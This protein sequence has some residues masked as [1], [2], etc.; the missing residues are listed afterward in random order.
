MT[1]RLAVFASGTG[2]NFASIAQAVRDRA[3]DVE[4][5]L[6][7]CDNPGAPVL[8]RAREF[9][10]PTLTFTPADCGTRLGYEQRILDSLLAESIDL[11]A[12]AG[13]MRIVRSPLLEAYA[14][15]I[16]NLH[17]AL[18]PAFPG[19]RAI[20]DAFEAGAS[21]TGVTVHFIDAGT[22]TGPIIAQR[23]VPID[24]GEGLEE[25]ESRIHQVEHQMYPEVLQS[26]IG[27]LR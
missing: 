19:V 2:S 1:V 17:P 10:V 11:V 21:E 16:V 22:D 13:Y 26:V 5:A 18:L 14:G 6:L 3:L 15:R 7:F 4:L 20:A 9:S 27:G 24:P 12:L 23:A 8:E 25:L